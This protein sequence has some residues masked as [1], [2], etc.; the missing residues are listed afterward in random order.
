M[1]VDRSDEY[2][3]LGP[4]S[5]ETGQW[6]GRTIIDSQGEP[7]WLQE[8]EEAESADEPTAGWDM[9]VQEYQGE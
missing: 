5:R 8:D 9:R 1:D 7:V 3:F 2:F 4:E 6:S